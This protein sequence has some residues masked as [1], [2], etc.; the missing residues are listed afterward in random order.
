MKILIV[1]FLS[2]F[3]IAC[4]GSSSTSTQNQ[5]GKDI[6]NIILTNRSANCSE[7]V[8]NYFSNVKDIQK[9]Q[10]FNGYLNITVENGKCKFSSNGIPNHNFNDANANFAH[11]VST[12]SLN[13]EITTSPINAQNETNLTLQ[14]NNAV[15]LNGV[16]VDLLAA[17]CFGVADG[18]IGCNDINQPWRYD[19]MSPHNNFGI[20]SHNAHTQPSGEY[21][22][23]GNP[24]ALYDTNGS[25]QSPLIG[26]AADGYPI[27]GLYISDNGTVRKVRSSYRLKSGSRVAKNGINPG[28]TYDGTFI[29][30]Y[31]FVS[32]SGD[33]DECNGMVRNGVYG[34]YL[35]DSFPW[36]LKCFKG[37]PDSSFRK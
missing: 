2:L 35:T 11:D 32:N 5:V 7:Y 3:F 10:D 22:Y 33:L 27:F 14:Y 25:S 24:L 4:G 20:D 36:I 29:D 1:C 30:D 28:G 19:P 17:A 23:H 31:E 13:V 9:N 8:Q 26:F 16:K 15:L 21:H 18:K 12:Q 6:T 37:T 34:Y